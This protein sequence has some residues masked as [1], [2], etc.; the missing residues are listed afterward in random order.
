MARVAPILL[1]LCAVALLLVATSPGCN[2]NQAGDAAS[3]VRQSGAPARNTGAISVV[4]SPE[5]ATLGVLA[6][7]YRPVTFSHGAHVK[8]SESCTT[9][10]HHSVG[11]NGTPLCRS[12]HTQPFQDQERPGLKGAYHRQCM[13]C[14]QSTGKGPLTCDGCHQKK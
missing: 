4:S 13:N 3:A 7:S 6:Q 8:L 5:V 12:C 10:H 2:G 14:H 9:C 11:E 1:L